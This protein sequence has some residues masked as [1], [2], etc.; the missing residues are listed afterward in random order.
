MVSNNQ[1][2]LARETESVAL[3]ISK[4]VGNRLTIKIGHSLLYLG[5]QGGRKATVFLGHVIV[6]CG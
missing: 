4:R 6:A 3:K 2:K 1:T 5:W